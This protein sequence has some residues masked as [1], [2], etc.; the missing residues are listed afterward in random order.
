MTIRTATPA[1]LPALAAAEAAC[2]PPAEAASEAVLAG[3]LAVYPN[4]FWLLERTEFW[5][6]SS[7]AW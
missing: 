3:R 5:S 1:D 2:F 6:V 7:T 4:H